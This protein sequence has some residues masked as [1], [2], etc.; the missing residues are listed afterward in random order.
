M[1]FKHVLSAAALSLVFGGAQAAT[2]TLTDD[3][4]L[5]PTFDVFGNS[6]DLTTDTFQFLLAP[7]TWSLQ[8]VT[9]NFTGATNAAISFD[10]GVFVPMS[11]F[12]VPGAFVFTQGYL[13][14]VGNGVDYHTLTFSGFNAGTASVTVSALQTAAPVP[15]PETYAMMLAGLGA[16]GFMA[17]RRQTK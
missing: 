14:V 8:D 3:I 9:V 17:R 6:G 15:E 7:G 5:D 2:V 13:G 10:G 1:N 16:L 4:E 11:S 12:A